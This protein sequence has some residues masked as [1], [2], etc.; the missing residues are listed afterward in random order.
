M[1]NKD[2]ITAQVNSTMNSLEGIQKAEAPPFLFTR[3]QQQIANSLDSNR[4]YKTVLRLAAVMVILL[5]INGYYFYNSTAAGNTA[6]STAA[7][8]VADYSLQYT[9]TD[10]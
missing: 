2:Y 5:M 6:K 9:P 10:F 8:V 1:K 7:M 3:I 4:L